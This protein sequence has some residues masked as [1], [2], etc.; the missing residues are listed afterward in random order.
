[1]N[2]TASNINS[3]PNSQIT[4]KR[5][6]ASI[7]SSDSEEGNADDLL[8]A[9]KPRKSSVKSKVSRTTKESPEVKAKTKRAKVEKKEAVGGSK[10]EEGRDDSWSPAEVISRDLNLQLGSAQS[11]VSLL[12]AGN[13][14]PFLA[15]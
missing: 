13:S 6:R 10:K 2:R 15:R 8:P 14:V 7:V 12:Q 9:K 1:M 5:V 4:M 3:A 11:T